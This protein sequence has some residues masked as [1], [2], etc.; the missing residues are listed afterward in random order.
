VTQQ[1]HQPRVALL[2]GQTEILIKR[3]EEMSSF[4]SG[5]V[6][7]KCALVLIEYQNEFTTEGRHRSCYERI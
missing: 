4:L 7:S 5:L 2:C 3:V 1:H 6:P